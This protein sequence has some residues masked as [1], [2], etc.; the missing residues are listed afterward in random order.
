VGIRLCAPDFLSQKGTARGGGGKVDAEP[1][2]CAKL[3]ILMLCF[4]HHSAP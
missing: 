3:S 1:K 4:L 2:K